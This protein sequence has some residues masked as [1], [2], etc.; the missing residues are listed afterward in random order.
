[1]KYKF[2]ITITGEDQTSFE[3]NVLSFA[4]S[5]GLIGKSIE[6]N[7]TTPE[8]A[9]QISKEINFPSVVNKLPDPVEVYNKIATAQNQPT[10]DQTVAVNNTPVSEIINGG[11][12]ELDAKGF[13]W[14]ERIHASTKTKNKDNT[15]K[16]RRGVSDELTRTVENE[17]RSK[18]VQNFEAP[19]N[20]TQ[21][22]PAG[23]Q[24]T[25]SAPVNPQPA[26]DPNQFRENTAQPT[27]FTA[28]DSQ[29]PAIK[30]DFNSLMTRISVL[31]S[32]ML[33]TPADLAT[34]CSKISQAHN[35]Q[36]NA[37]TDISAHQNMVD[38]AI[39]VLKD[40]GKWL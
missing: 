30:N 27:V 7:K 12:V 37:I 8:Q 2:K 39:Q 10:I 14:D 38:Y 22:P 13:P 3:E 9:K 17:L 33:L 19:V 20:P 5:L 35:V 36:I 6:L 31:F 1:M 16:S 29:P 18:G 21:Q 11:T 34:L 24:F 40:E 4:T 23:T 28:G 32:Q 26:F 25:S 15:W